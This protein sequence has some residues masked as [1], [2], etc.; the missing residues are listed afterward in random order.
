MVDVRS[1]TPSSVSVTMMIL[2]D[3]TA[4]IRLPTTSRRSTRRE[5]VI[6]FRAEIDWVLAVF[7]GGILDSSIA[8]WRV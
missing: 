7:E 8:G 3:N 1:E 5:I 4:T 2:P 6:T